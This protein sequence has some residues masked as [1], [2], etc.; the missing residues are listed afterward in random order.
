MIHSLRL[1]TEALEKGEVVCIFP[2]GQMTRI[3]QMLRFAGD[4]SAL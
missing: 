3:G 1:A 2:E 4:L